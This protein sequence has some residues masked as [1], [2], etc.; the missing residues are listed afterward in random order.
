M[1]K[2]T[3]LLLVI[4]GAY[5]ATVYVGSPQSAPCPDQE[6]PCHSLDYYAEHTS[7]EWPS[8][9]KVVFQPG[10]HYLNKNLSVTVTNT[11]NLTLTAHSCSVETV[12]KCSQNAGFVFTN[13]KN[14]HIDCLAIN[15]C[16]LYSA[17]GACHKLPAAVRVESSTNVAV[18]NVKIVNSLGYGL[19]AQDT[20]GLFLISN[21]LFQYNGGNNTLYGGN[22]QAFYEN[23]AGSSSLYI[24]GTNFEHGYNPNEGSFA[25]G[26]TVKLA[27]LNSTINVLIENTTFTNNTSSKGNGYGGH[28]TVT[29]SSLHHNFTFVHCKF[30]SGAANT[31]GAIYVSLNP[32]QSSLQRTTMTGLIT[33]CLFECNKADKDGAAVHLVFH[34]YALPNIDGSSHATNFT[35][36]NCTFLNNKVK[37]PTSSY[38]AAI[39]SKVVRT[40]AF[41]LL[42]VPQFQLFISN[43]T[44]IGNSQLNESTNNSYV[45]GQVYLTETTFVWIN[46]STITN[47]KCSG[48]LGDHSI[49][50]FSGSI[51]ISENSAVRGGGMYLGG[52]SQFYLTP[53]TNVSINNNHANYGGGMY[54][55]LI[56]ECF[57]EDIDC[58]FQLDETIQNNT[59]LLETV[60][61]RFQ[62]N[63]AKITGYDIFGGSVLKCYILVSFGERIHFTGE[64][65][66]KK[67]F[68]F[69]AKDPAHIS[70]PPL[71]VCFC[72]ELP[73]CTHK[74][75]LNLTI[76]PGQNIN[77][78]VILVGQLNGPVPGKVIIKGD[79]NVRLLLVEYLQ[80]ISNINC[81]N[82]SLTVYSN[83]SVATLTLTADAQCKNDQ[84]VDRHLHIAFKKCPVGFI[85]YPQND[86]CECIGKPYFSCNLDN[87]TI[88][89]DIDMIHW[90]GYDISVSK[91]VIGMC[92]YDYCKQGYVAFHTTPQ[93]FEH[94]S[95]CNFDRIG[96][97][98][99]QCPEN[100]SAV[101]GSSVC[102]KCGNEFLFV[103]VA[104]AVGGLLIVMFITVL[105]ITVSHGAINGLIF[106]SNIVHVLS[107]Q[108]FPDSVDHKP[109]LFQF[110]S[111]LNFSLG[112]QTCFYNSMDT[113]SKAWL[114]W[115]FPLYLILLVF[116]IVLGARHS[117][118]IMRLAGRNSTNVLAT[119]LL[120]S[121]SKIILN[122]VSVFVFTPLY[123]HP[124]E[125]LWKY[126]WSL[127]GNIEY[128][129]TEHLLLIIVGVCALILTV[130]YITLL[131][132]AQLIRHI[133]HRFCNWISHLK[134]FIDAYTG[135][136]KD[137]CVF[138]TGHLL[139][140][141][142]LICVVATI[143]VVH[144]H[145]IILGIVVGACIHI[146]TL[147]V[148]LFRGVYKHWALDILESS[149]ILNTCF[150]AIATALVKR[151]NTS[152]DQEWITYTSVSAA[153]ATFIGIVF[154]HI[155]LRLSNISFYLAI[156]KY[157]RRMIHRP[158]PELEAILN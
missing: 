136:Y 65:V 100:K 40:A 137:N 126:V 61:V 152:V 94:N 150:L 134:P 17:E 30:R 38:G 139:L 54:I 114:Q 87:Q 13:V 76:Y 59:S 82:I 72:D 50:M 115:C 156:T 16:G 20:E 142:G 127:D 9:T 43:C 56:S 66:F 111:W 74:S 21:S 141:R 52:G 7:E 96:I 147:S 88:T 149:F 121:F 128:G 158:S 49:I 84:L 70:S 69:A 42:L 105:D 93:S 153:F 83:V 113:Y 122:I 36:S 116:V 91:V 145:G 4:S 35:F 11:T 97:L 47:S 3:I 8:G 133:N 101:L 144:N 143:G 79:H 123:Y 58:I 135:I 44:F 18:S 132:F 109:V 146:L 64:K 6:K 103:L 118:L 1:M 140:V 32:K 27:C 157:F 155:H 138:W 10:T 14:L 125:T 78:E 73:D 120:L 92:P 148:W 29:M 39:H 31:G 98:C 55:D 110:I 129:S 102:L 112:I 15:G 86:Y 77:V 25:P 33:N 19:C 131:L 71:G 22:F 51:H 106:Y 89:K 85:G 119:L 45:C 67:V 107:T 75:S 80:V 26:V 68:T 151:G 34:Q 24:H 2:T 53:Y 95:Q 37:A 117:T 90:I 62:G 124:S 104:F 60:D 81:T 154:Y 23:C 130:P 99:G 63:L 57:L 12:V 48:I 108:V 5:C 46:T 41:Q 28:V